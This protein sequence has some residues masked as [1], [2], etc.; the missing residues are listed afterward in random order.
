M[1][2]ESCRGGSTVYTPGTAVSS[3]LASRSVF[4]ST[5][6][7]GI[8][9]TSHAK[10][11]EEGA[12]GQ[13]EAESDAARLSSR[14]VTAKPVTFHIQTDVEGMIVFTDAP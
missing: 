14:S 3:W 1:R 4:Q 7:A 10:K 12:K 11:C 5:P 9:A 2:G 13:R 8:R 6:C